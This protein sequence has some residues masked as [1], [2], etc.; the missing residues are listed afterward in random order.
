MTKLN[1]AAETVVPASVQKNDE[2]AKMNKDETAQ[3]KPVSA[4]DPAVAP[5]K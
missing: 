2:L 3:A 4:P 5:Q 1:M